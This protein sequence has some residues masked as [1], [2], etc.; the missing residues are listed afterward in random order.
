MQAKDTLHTKGN[1][2]LFYVR[3]NPQL[4]KCNDRLT[5]SVFTGIIK[6]KI[7]LLKSKTVMLYY[8][9]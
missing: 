1:V 9:C 8:D 5:S 6:K 7:M 4:K 3:Q 2:Q